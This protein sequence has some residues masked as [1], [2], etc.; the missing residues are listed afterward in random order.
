M[1]NAI[2]CLNCRLGTLREARATHAQ[3][4]GE[5]LVLVP[6]VAAWR[7]DVCGDFAYDDETLTRVELLLGSR[8]EQDGQS[9]AGESDPSA[10]DRPRK[11]EVSDG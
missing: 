5:E 8:I 4:L 7:C 9:A 1:D 10:S 3:W 11:G 6:G 2:Q